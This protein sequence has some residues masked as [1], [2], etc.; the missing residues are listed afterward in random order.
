[1][2]RNTLL[3][4]SLII[5]AGLLC[6]IIYFI[7]I[8]VAL[9]RQ[10]KKFNGIAV[11]NIFLGWT[12][13]GWVAAL[14]WATIDNQYEIKQKLI[15]TWLKIVFG[16]LVI[17]VLAISFIYIFVYN[18]PHDDFEKTKPAYSLTAADLYNA[19]IA[20]RKVSEAKYNGQVIEIRGM[21]TKIEATDS[22]VIAVFVF[23]QGVFGD[24]GIR[25]SMLQKYH[26][27][28]RLLPPQSM[29]RIKGYC[30][31]Y[32]DTDVIIEQSCIIK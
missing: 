20:E 31:G 23:N 19:F 4:G 7:P 25:C 3:T 10:C 27:E 32:N 12:I 6:V 1:M 15:K 8:F 9:K 2:D 21:L 16:L 26:D 24:E 13:L 11:L 30:T 28:T 18:K 29:V 14:I 5:V 22:S 17:G